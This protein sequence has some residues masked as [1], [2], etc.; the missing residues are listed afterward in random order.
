MIGINFKILL[1]TSELFQGY[2]HLTHILEFK[3]ALAAAGCA[4]DSELLADDRIRRAHIIGE[5][6]GQLNLRY[7]LAIEGRFAYGWF[8]GKDQVRRDFHTKGQQLTAAEAA[9][10]KEKIDAQRKASNA[11]RL[12][13]Q[14]QA[15]E[16]ADFIWKSATPAQHDEE[17]LARKGIGPGPAR[18]KRG[19]LMLPMFNDKGLLCS[20]QFIKGAEKRYLRDGAKG[21]L[22]LV[23]DVEKVA[24]C[25]GFATGYSIHA[26]TGWTVVVCFD[27]AGLKLGAGRVRDI[28]PLADVTVCADND[29]WVFKAG[30]KPVELMDLPPGDD[31][32]WTEWRKADLL[33]N[34]GIE[35]ATAALKKVGGNA[36]I[37]NPKFKN[38]ASRPTDFNDLQAAEGLAAVTAQ[39]T[40]VEAPP[41]ADEPP[42]YLEFAPMAEQDLREELPMYDP[43]SVCS[44]IETGPFKLMGYNDGVYYYLPRASGQLVGL[45]AGGHNKNNL[46]QL[47]PLEWWKD[48]FGGAKG[49]ISWDHAMNALIKLCH[50]RGVF[51]TE[52]MIRGSGVWLD[53]GRVIAHCGDRL[54]VDG[55]E[56][57]PFEVGSAFVYAKS[58]RIFDI[59]KE[60]L[61][62]QQAAKLLKVFQLMKW[63]NPISAILAAGWTTIAPLSGALNWRPHIY[64]DGEK[65][66]GKSWVNDAVIKPALGKCAIR[67]GS[68]TTEAGLRRMVGNDA[69]PIIMDEMEGEDKKQREIRQAILLM[70]R[71]ASSGESMVIADSSGKGTMVFKIF[72]MFSMSSINTGVVQGADLSR[73]SHLQLVKNNSANSV[74]EFRDIQAFVKETLT[75]SYVAA[76]QR[77]TVDNAKTILKNCQTFSEAAAII[78]K[79]RRA[80]DQ[81]GPMLAGAYSLHNTHEVSIEKAM[82]WVKDKDWTNHTSIAE[83]ADHEKLFDHLSTARL[84]VI[85]S[86]KRHETQ[87]GQAI[88]AAFGFVDENYTANEARQALQAIDIKI[89]QDEVWLRKPSQHIGRVLRDTPWETSWHSSIQNVDGIRQS[90]TPQ[91]F[92]SSSAIVISVP[93]EKFRPEGMLL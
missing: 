27:T 63:R 66:S 87:I 36:R 7:R 47:A 67:V 46:M 93:K 64:I 57:E 38:T 51:R 1:R 12:E 2:N 3:A 49:A 17:Y 73:F 82:D 34:P 83:K 65:G 74:E 48:R 8:V 88:A 79:D 22:T 92:G 11:A 23:G 39:L 78:L 35:A 4:T 60:A 42:E 59:G 62:D 77:R 72:S 53:K 71:K 5:R 33:F 28:Y 55:A 16:R 50:E 90:K 40:T 21:T 25:E 84:V 86:S 37:L 41:A 32:A 10:Q 19:V 80:G 14:R 26:A 13:A 81:I 30:R 85:G 76:L 20:L 6:Q 52:T 61:D 45:T 44:P 91:S 70:A 24:I 54:M 68:G 43:E 75:E 31:P 29:E 15:A 58:G 56:T 18:V 9:A 69:R 89:K